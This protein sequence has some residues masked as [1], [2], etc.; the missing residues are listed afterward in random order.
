MQ[1]VLISAS[2]SDERTLCHDWIV[3]TRFYS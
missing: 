3:F 1:N 2:T